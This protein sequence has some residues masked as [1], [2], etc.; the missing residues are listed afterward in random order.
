M[1]MKKENKISLLEN[2]DLESW[3]EIQNPYPPRNVKCPV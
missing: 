1:Y 3:K 2:L